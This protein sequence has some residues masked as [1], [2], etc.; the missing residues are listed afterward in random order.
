M[1]DVQLMRDLTFGLIRLKSAK[2][3]TALPADVRRW[4]CPA[5]YKRKTISGYALG[6]GSALL[7]LGQRPYQRQSRI[8]NEPLL[9]RGK[10]TASHRAAQP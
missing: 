7:L 1:L 6:V 8:V 5:V 9:R 4:L 3:N 10:A 2:L